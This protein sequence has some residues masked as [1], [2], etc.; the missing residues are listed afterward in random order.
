M[1]FAIIIK[2]AYPFTSNVKVI[3]LPFLAMFAPHMEMEERRPL[4]CSR[5]V[6]TIYCVK[7]NGEQSRE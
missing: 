2:D 6:Y 1:Q 5:A 7:L 4:A 3:R